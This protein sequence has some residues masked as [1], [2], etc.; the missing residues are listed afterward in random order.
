M[1]IVKRQPARPPSVRPIDPYGDL[2]PRE[3]ASAQQQH[4]DDVQAWRA[5]FPREPD[6]D[7]LGFILAHAA[8]LEDWQRDIVSILRDEAAYFSPQRRTKIANEG[9]AVW[10][11]SQIV[12]GL[13][14]PTDEFVEYDRL[15]AS[16]GQPHQMSVNPYNL[17]YELWKEVERIYD[18][19]TD[20]ERIQFPG[21]GEISGRARVLELAAVCD[22]VSLIAQFLTPGVAERCKLLAWERE[23]G[24]QNR[25]RITTREAEE[26]RDKLVTDLSRRGTPRILVTDGDAFRKGALWL[27]H[28][29]EGSGLDA[30]YAQG[31]LPAVARLWGRAV[32]L[33]TVES[34]T[35][36]KS[37]P[38]PTGVPAPV[39][40]LKPAW[41]VAHPDDEMATV[42]TER[43][44]G[45]DRRA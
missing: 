4:D 21:A 19:P 12:Q 26:I 42:L 27:E 39:T 10:V 41:F 43:P 25:V 15:N 16:V 5:R 18:H 34:V 9:F 45:L 7:L 35:T 44:D 23:P 20:E 28:R 1:D 22:D 31:T 36:A 30:E 17:G 32:Y 3:A 33:E 40:E 8:R 13:Q 38:T 14:L 29:H 2:F 6:A 37:T 24:E 11:H